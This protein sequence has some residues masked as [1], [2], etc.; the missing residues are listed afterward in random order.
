MLE[1]RLGS[2]PQGHQ[3]VSDQATTKLN[4]ESLPTGDIRHL[5]QTRLGVDIPPER[6]TRQVTDKADGNPPFVVEIVRY[7]ARHSA[8][9]CG[10]SW[11]APAALP[12]SVQS[13]L[14]ARGSSCRRR[15]CAPASGVGDRKAISRCC[16]RRGQHR[17]SARGDSGTRLGPCSRQIWRFAFKHALVRGA[18]Y[19]SLLTA[20]CT[21]LYAKIADQTE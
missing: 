4:L 20:A 11:T 7:R 19:Q 16:R 1:L 18:L 21:R 8:S 2:I 17:Y 9:R 10:Q 13:L 14:T 12:A 15:P 3:P 6:L 5:V